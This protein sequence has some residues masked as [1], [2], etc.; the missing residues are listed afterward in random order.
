MKKKKSTAPITTITIEGDALYYAGEIR[1][2]GDSGATVYVSNHEQVKSA[3]KLVFNDGD[4]VDVTI[5]KR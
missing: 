3:A 2:S 5:K 4:I 1:F